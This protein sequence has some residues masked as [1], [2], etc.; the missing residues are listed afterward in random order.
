MGGSWE[1]IWQEAAYM[2][3]HR[4]D[5]WKREWWGKGLLNPRKGSGETV[6]A[7]WGNGTVGKGSPEL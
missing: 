4:I 6:L 2:L 5:P 1:G 3:L 7:C